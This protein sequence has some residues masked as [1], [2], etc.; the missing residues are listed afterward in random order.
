MVEDIGPEHVVHIVTDNGSNYKKACKALGEVYEHIVWT[1]CLAHTVNLMLKDI[2]QRPEYA[3]TIK[4]CK[5]ISNWLHNHG[6]LNAMMRNAIGGNQL[7]YAK[8]RCSL[9]TSN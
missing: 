3:G 2:A 7:H 8:E 1:S 6:K 4:H 5:V 9:E